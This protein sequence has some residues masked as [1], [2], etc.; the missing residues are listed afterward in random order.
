MGSIEF[1]WSDQHFRFDLRGSCGEC[2]KLL[3]VMREFE[4]PMY[5]PQEDQREEASH[6]IAEPAASP[7]GGPGMPSGNSGVS[8]GPP[9]V[10]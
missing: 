1:S 6:E 3:D 9:S 7:N 10:S 2:Q 8:G 5:D 4:C